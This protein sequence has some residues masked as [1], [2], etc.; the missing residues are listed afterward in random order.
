[1]IRIGKCF[2]EKGYLMNYISSVIFDED[3]Q[4]MVEY[5]LIIGLI[6]VA[7]VVV[8]IALGP[9]VANLYNV[10]IPTTTSP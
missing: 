1:M 6:S 9:K 5:G 7:A 3:G 4:S 2:L 8:L 10:N